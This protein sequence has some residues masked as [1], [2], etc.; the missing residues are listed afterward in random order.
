VG[1][2]TLEVIGAF[3]RGETVAVIA[4]GRGVKVGTVIKHLIAAWGD[5]EEIDLEGTVPVELRAEIERAFGGDFSGMLRD[6]K[7]RCGDAVTYEH[8]HVMRAL[9]AR[10]AG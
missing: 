7:D 1:D 4:A 9:L 2:A 8:L 3:R 5:G 10:R 6:V